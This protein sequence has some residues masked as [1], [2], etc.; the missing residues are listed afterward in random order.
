M[1]KYK[2]V[3]E[4]VSVKTFVDTVHRTDYTTKKELGPYPA[5]YIKKHLLSPRMGVDAV[6]YGMR[7]KN[8]VKP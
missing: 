1:K 2:N 7:T 4:N 5:E 3:E 8:S 6:M